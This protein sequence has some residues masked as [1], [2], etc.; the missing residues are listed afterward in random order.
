M[1]GYIIICCLL[2]FAATKPIG[3]A[4]TARISCTSS[5]PV[6]LTLITS[7]V[8]YASPVSDPQLRAK[9]MLN[10]TFKRLVAV[11]VVDH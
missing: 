7:Q 11:Q 8:I 2:R 9:Y 10:M 6:R 3:N 4:T 1:W 5:G